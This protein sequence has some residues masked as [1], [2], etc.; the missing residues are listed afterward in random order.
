MLLPQWLS[1]LN[2]HQSHLEDLNHRWLGTTLKIS[3][4]VNSNL[5]VGWIPGICNCH[6]FLGGANATGWG[7][8]IEN[9]V[10]LDFS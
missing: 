10:L 3:D 1:N 7:L 6:K 4:F 9:T 2:G 5:G 8:H